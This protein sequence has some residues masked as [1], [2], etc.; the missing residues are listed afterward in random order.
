MISQL[1]SDPKMR[2]LGMALFLVVSSVV[3]GYGVYQGKMKILGLLALFTAGFLLRQASIRNAY[4]PS[5]TALQLSPDRDPL[6]P[7]AEAPGPG[8]LDLLSLAR[9]GSIR[10]AMCLGLLITT[11]LA[12]SDRHPSSR[13][14][15][16]TCTRRGPSLRRADVPDS[17]RR[18]G[19][20]RRSHGSPG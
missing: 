19:P 7:R 11:R 2:R 15:Y 5:I 20:R 3:A 13:S 16:V 4:W 12:M 17:S 14:R 8:D 6:A 1:L 18:R 10:L 9:S